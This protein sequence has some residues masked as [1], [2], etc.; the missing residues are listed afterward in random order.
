MAPRVW[1]LTVFL[2]LM[3]LTG[4][5]VLG[6]AVGWLRHAAPQLVTWGLPS[7]LGEILASV[8]VVFKLQWTQKETVSRPRANKLRVNIAFDGFD[9]ADVV[10]DGANC[11]YE[12]YDET[13]VVQKGK[14]APSLG[15][16]GWQIVLPANLP[17]SHSV[18]LL[19]RSQDGRSWQVRPFLAFVHKQTAYRSKA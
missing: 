18:K 14:V 4:V 17:E 12:V 5:A 9:T 19:L 2:L 3:L 8:I 6:A 1:V 13:E 11:S 10:L 16:G 7:F 15:P